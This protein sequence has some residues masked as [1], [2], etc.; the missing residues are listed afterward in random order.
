M[1]NKH[2]NFFSKKVFP[3]SPPTYE[4]KKKYDN[5]FQIEKPLNDRIIKNI[6]DKF[7]S[8]LF[9]IILSPFFLIIFLS[10]SIESLFSKDF[11]SYIYFYY[12]VSKG[13]KFKKYKFRTFKSN[14]IDQ[15]FKKNNDWRAYIIDQKLE[16]LTYTGKFIKKFYL[17][18]LPQL[19]NI[20][21]GDMSFVG[22]RPLSEIH[23]KKDIEQG[24]KVRLLVKGGLI[25]LGHL[26]K[27]TNNM[28][29]PEYELIYV[30]NYIELK[31]L[32]LLIFD[33][34]IIS[35]GVILSSK[36]GNH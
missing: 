6:F 8:F 23:Y 30:Q 12:A 10:Y 35:K 32:D 24:N 29:L 26:N 11:G 9:L 25:G 36:G 28:G 5:I 2:K 18:E 21:T 22:P 31:P 20:L 33:L 16:N 17:D 4:L 13:K 34:K 14:L 1:H 19:F 15:N 3:Y 27:G 7:F